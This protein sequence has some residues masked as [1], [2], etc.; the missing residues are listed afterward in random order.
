MR[1][2]APAAPVVQAAVVPAAPA[3]PGLPAA[4]AGPGA[5]AAVVPEAATDLA[6]WLEEQAAGEAE[7][8][9]DVSK[10]CPRRKA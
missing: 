9:V 10:F 6:A 2:A 5:Q 4:A 3:A 8:A 1:A 7:E